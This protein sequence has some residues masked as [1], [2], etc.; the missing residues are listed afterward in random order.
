MD[1]SKLNSATS[2]HSIGNRSDKTIITT[3]KNSMAEPHQTDSVNFSP[4]AVKV[5]RQDQYGVQTDPMKL[6]ND[7]VDI[8]PPRSISLA[9]P[10]PY[11]ELLPETQEY[12]D[13]LNKRLEKA[14]SPEQRE[15]IE[16]YISGASRFG[17]KEMIQSDSQI[18]TRWQVEQVTVDLMVAHSQINNEE[19]EVPKGLQSADGSSFSGMKTLDDISVPNTK[20]GTLN[21]SNAEKLSLSGAQHHER[22]EEFFYGWLNGSRT[23]EDEIKS[24][25]ILAQ[26]FKEHME[27]YLK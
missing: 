8:E 26:D 4:A 23:L 21:K 15:Q 25:E 16:A 11:D 12:I 22:L 24:R 5:Q 18:K 17:D 9:G 10:K 14:K 2:A 7:W 19:I 6:Y 27:N 3:Q 20:S 1:I 13:H